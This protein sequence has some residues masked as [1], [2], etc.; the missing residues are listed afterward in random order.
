MSILY[1]NKNVIKGLS[2]RFS[3]ITRFGG[4]LFH[5]SDLASLWHVHDP[6]VLRVTLKRYTD[7][8]VLFRVY[9]GFYAT[10]PVEQINPLLLGQKALHRFSYIS[11]ETV[12]A[13][14]GVIVQQSDIITFVSSVSKKFSIAKYDFISRQLAD[15]F[16]Y[17]EYHVIMGENGVKKATAER[18]VAD[19]L[20]FNPKAYFDADQ[21]I[22]WKKVQDIQRYVGYP[23]T[24]KRYR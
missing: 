12:L 13:Q 2:E 1:N 5:V 24:L 3:K 9:R 4:E 22:D 10:K 8:G 15:K 6:H 19:M 18:A 17:N 20:Y 7:R 14:T 23:M 21:N 11:T 16:L